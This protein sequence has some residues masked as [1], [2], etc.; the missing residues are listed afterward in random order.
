MHGRA[1]QIKL[2]RMVSTR[3]PSLTLAVGVASAGASAV[4][5]CVTRWWVLGDPNGPVATITGLL[6]GLLIGALLTRMLRTGERLRAEQAAVVV[7]IGA[8]AGAAAALACDPTLTPAGLFAGATVALLMLPV[9]SAI[10]R[11]AHRALR[12]RERSLVG[13]IDRRA[14]WLAASVA[15]SIAASAG[16]IAAFTMN[17]RWV[18]HYVELVAVPLVVAG[19]AAAIAVAVY[20]LDALTASRAHRA[21]AAQQR[22][23]QGSG[24]AST[25]AATVDIGVGNATWIEGAECVESYRT[26]AEERVTIVGDVALAPKLVDAAVRQS[27]IVFGV[28]ASAL[29]LAFV[30]LLMVL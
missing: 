5:A 16:T 3:V 26:L 21:V 15:L 11:F 23:R 28:A 30:A 17:R 14:P 27:M 29:N 13:G 1:S 4:F 25:T 7:S 22:L 24:P 20:T 18:R 9:L 2:M 19:V 12:S 8:I 6:C 10:A